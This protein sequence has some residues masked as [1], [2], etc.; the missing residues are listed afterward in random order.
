MHAI[1][2]EIFNIVS[3][4]I[5]IL[6][7]VSAVIPFQDATMGPFSEFGIALLT[8]EDIDGNVGEVP[9]YSSYSI[10]LETCLLPI[11]FHGHGSTYRDIYPRL[12]WSIRNEGF[13]GQAAALLGQV[14][15]AL[16]DLAARRSNQP[17][18]KYIGAQRNWVKMYGSGGG[19]NYSLKELER[20]IQLFLNAGIDCYKMKV[21]AKFGSQPQED[22][23]RVKFVRSL[24]GPEVKLAVDANQVWSFKE[25]VMF[26]ELTECVQLAWLEE[27]IHSA[28]LQQ[29][30]QLCSHSHVAIAY[31]ES[32]RTS[33]IFPTLMNI[34]VRHFQPAPAQLGS[35][36]EWMEVR[37]LAA[38]SKAAFSSGGYSLFNSFLMTSAPVENYVE[39][40]YSI[41]YGLEQYFC[42]KPEW[43]N[44]QFLLPDVSGVP[45]RVDWDYCTR[46]QK[47]KRELNWTREIVKSYTPVVTL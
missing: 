40:L 27:P 31:G 29:I 26:L 16:Y 25:A 32:E 28:D 38:N 8:L 20:E 3:A 30:E 18:Y 39:Y 36:K 7:P 42:V 45:V 24:L 19:T 34:G 35:I 33:K 10:I 5:R 14:D 23:E 43:K 4:R 47:I 22:A 46:N 9:V 1:E 21:G 44:G 17:L 2:N 13:R 37:D 6:E 15:M 41:M 11:L 12:Y